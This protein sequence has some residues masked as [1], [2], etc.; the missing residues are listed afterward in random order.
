MTDTIIDGLKIFIATCPHLDAGALLKVNS[1]GTEPVQYSIVP[2]PGQRVLETYLNDVE[3]CEYPFAIQSV[4]STANDLERIDS[5]GVF[6]KIMLWL[7]ESTLNETLPTL[8]T[9]HIAK[10]IDAVNWSFLF[11]QGV[12]ETGVYQIQCRLR[13][14]LQP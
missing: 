8:P 6:E 2:Q 4:E 3:V 5:L 7:K 1:L 14:E 9:K 10:E 12:S 13:Y 11:E